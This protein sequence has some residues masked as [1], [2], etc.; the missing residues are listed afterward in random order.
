M[1]ASGTVTQDIEFKA[2]EG[3]LSMMSK[4]LN[5]VLDLYVHPQPNL[6]A[7][8]VLI[9]MHIHSSNRMDSGRF[10]SVLKPYKFHQVMRSLF[11]PLRMATDA[12][13]LE[14]VTDLDHSI[15]GVRTLPIRS[16]Y[17]R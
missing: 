6:R 3:S 4:V 13:K 17:I 1:Q 5:D 8:R 15:D 12:R 14:F 10:E 7:P 9:A 11:V 2:L 16:I